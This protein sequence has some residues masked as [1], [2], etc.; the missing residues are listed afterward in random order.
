[1]SIPTCKHQFSDHTTCNA[2]AQ[3]GKAYCMWHRTESDRRRR[4]V[5]TQRVPRNKRILLTMSNNRYIVSH[6]LQQV[7]DAICANR[8][9]NKRAGLL[10]YAIT[11]SMS[12]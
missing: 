5:R 11:N 7:I 10:L 12:S 4:Y 8:L 3:Q 6:N 1:M 2:V 9:S